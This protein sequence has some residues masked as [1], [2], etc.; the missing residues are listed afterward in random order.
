LEKSLIAQAFETDEKRVARE[1]REALVRGVAVSGGIEREHL[2]ELLS[3]C[4]KKVSKFVGAWAE[5]AD[6]EASG[7]G[8]EVKED[9]TTA[10]EF[11]L[12]R[13]RRRTVGSQ[14]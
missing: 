6:S 2:P 14:G 1:G 7:K 11:H 12:V 9:A 8:S 3:G 10:R 5:I 4:G 13:I